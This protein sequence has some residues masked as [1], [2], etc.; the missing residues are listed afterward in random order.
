M[1]LCL[2][3]ARSVQMARLSPLVKTNQL[4]IV[5]NSIQFRKPNQLQLYEPRV[6]VSSRAMKSQTAEQYEYKYI[7]PRD[8]AQWWA[9]ERL[10]AAM[11]MV[12]VPI[13]LEFH[14]F[15]WMVRWV[16]LLLALVIVPHIHWGFESIIEDYIRPGTFGKIIPKLAH[17]LLYILSSLTLGGFFL[18]NKV[19]V[20]INQVIK[21]LCMM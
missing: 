14:Q 7:K 16:D 10:F 18:F 4:A 17:Y 15:H 2:K 5:S 6:L 8:Q 20:G 3:L 19:D 13:C 12:T 21:D 9:A 1:A 11:V